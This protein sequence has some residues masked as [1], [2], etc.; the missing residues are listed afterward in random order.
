[1][2]FHS[3][4]Q[5]VFAFLNKPMWWKCSRT[6]QST[7]TCYRAVLLYSCFQEWKMWPMLSNKLEACKQK[8]HRFLF[9]CNPY[10]QIISSKALLTKHNI[11]RDMLYFLFQQFKCKIYMCTFKGG[12]PVVFPILNLTL[13]I[14]HFRATVT[15]FKSVLGSCFDRF[16]CNRCDQTIWSRVHLRKHNDLL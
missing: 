2:S 3:K 6:V 8:S 10:D 1:M 15:W 7:M 12:Y 13:V 11:G 14:K 9:S 5:L 4:E 16:K